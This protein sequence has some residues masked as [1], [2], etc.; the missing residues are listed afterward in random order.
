MC[1]WFCL[2]GGILICLSCYCKY[3]YSG[4]CCEK[5]YGEFLNDLV[6]FILER[7]GGMLRILNYCFEL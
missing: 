1:N 6:V 2:N 3:G 4:V 7:E 5:G